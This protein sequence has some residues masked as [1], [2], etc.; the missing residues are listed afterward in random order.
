MAIKTILNFILKRYCN[1]T[2]YR[3]KN[4]ID[5]RKDGRTFDLFSTKFN[6]KFLYSS[7]IY[8]LWLNKSSSAQSPICLAFFQI[9]WSRLP[10]QKIKGLR[11]YNSTLIKLSYDTPHFL[12]AHFEFLS[13]V[14]AV[15]AKK[16]IYTFLFLS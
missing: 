12:V 5:S 3:Q 13:R 15:V 1:E 10:I 4:A 7:F 14:E 16:N 8:N 2:K 11:M 9:C 6:S